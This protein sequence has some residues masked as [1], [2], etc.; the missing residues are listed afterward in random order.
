MKKI[1]MNMKQGD[2]IVCPHCKKDSFWV[3]TNLMDGWTFKGEILIC[4]LCKQKIADIKKNNVKNA[5]ESGEKLNNFAAFLGEEQTHKQIIEDSEEKPFCR[6]CKHYISH[7]FMNRCQLH[8]K[9]V[10]PM[11]DCRDFI[12]QKS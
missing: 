2:E 10:N 11:N 5:P 8:A 9:E 4:S 12:K 1:G 7:P 6:D 3:K